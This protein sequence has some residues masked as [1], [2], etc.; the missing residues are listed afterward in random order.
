MN[1]KRPAQYSGAR[2]FGTF[3]HS[4]R[5]SGT[6]SSQLSA[7]KEHILTTV[8]LGVWLNSNIST[9]TSEGLKPYDVVTTACGKRVGLLGFLIDEPTAFPKGRFKVCTRAPSR[10][11]LHMCSSS[12]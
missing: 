9:L 10:G 6:L 11:T 7:A 3:L 2:L 8:F 1:A 5:F 12:L 4:H